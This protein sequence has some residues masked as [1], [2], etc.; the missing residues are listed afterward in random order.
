LAARLSD[1]PGGGQL[2]ITRGGSRAGTDNATKLLAP[3]FPNAGA[4]IPTG[5]TREAHLT[6][7][8]DPCSGFLDCSTCP[9]KL[10]PTF[11]NSALAGSILILDHHGD[12]RLFLCGRNRLGRVLGR[13]GLIALASASPLVLELP[14]YTPG[15]CRKPKRMG[16][17]TDS[18]PRDGDDGI[19]FPHV[20]LNQASL[21]PI[22][23]ALEDGDEIRAVLQDVEPN[24]YH[25]IL[26]GPWMPLRALVILGHLVVGE[27]ALLFLLGHIKA[28]GVRLDL[29]QL[30]LCAEALSSALLAFLLV[31]PFCSFYW[32]WIPYG[33]ATALLLGGT[34]AHQL[35]HRHHVHVSHVFLSHHPLTTPS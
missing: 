3:T 20:D 25:F 18:L 28:H 9:P 34:G 8:S 10:D 35:H 7:L 2:E 6:W 30:A 32:G 22:L 23:A 14:L 26:Y 12:E 4:P 33:A 13:S 24:P 19:P 29:A 31:D 1:D 5:G 27:R 11:N 16:E 15:Y 17:Y 21:P